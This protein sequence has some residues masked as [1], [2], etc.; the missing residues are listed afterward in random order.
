MASLVIVSRSQL[1]PSHQQQIEKWNEKVTGRSVRFYQADVSDPDAIHNLIR[2]VSKEYQITAVYH[3]A[4]VV[5]DCSL[6]SMTTDQLTRAMNGKVWGA[7]HLHNALQ[8][9]WPLA[10]LVL[11]SSISV[12]L[13]TPGQGN[14]V[15]A[16]ACLEGLAN[17]RRK[18]HLPVQLLNWGHWA[19][20]GMASHLDQRQWAYMN[21]Q[22]ITPVTSAQAFVA[23]SELQ[24][25]W[26]HNTDNAPQ[27]VTV[28][29]LNKEAIT[30]NPQNLLSTMLSGSVDE[31]Q[32]TSK[33]ESQIPGKNALP[34]TSAMEDFQ[35]WPLSRIQKHVATR[36]VN[37]L[38]RILP[39]GGRSL[40]NSQPLERQGLDSLLGVEF[41]S[42]VNNEFR[43]T[44][45]GSLLFNYPTVDAL[46]EHLSKEIHAHVRSSVKTTP[47]AQSK[48]S[49]SIAI[50][51]MGCRFPGGVT[52]PEEFWQLLVNNTDAITSCPADR[53]EIDDWYAPEPG[54]PAKM[55]SR[56]GGF[57]SDIY[58]FDTQFF[59]VNPHEAVFLDPRQRLLMEVAWEALQ[60]AGQ[61]CKRLNNSRTSVY[62]GFC[63]SEYQGLV[64]T[65]ASEITPYSLL[66]TSFSAMASRLSY[67]LGLNGPNIALD[68]ACSSS[69]VAIDM[70]CKSLRD[71]DSDLAIAGGSNLLLTPESSVYFSQ[72]KALSPSDRYHSFGA[73][74]DGYV[75]AEG[76]GVVILKRLDRA[77][78]D[79]DPIDAIIRSVAVNQDGRS[80]GPTAPNGL[81]QRNLLQ[82]VLE[83]AHVK[84][85]QV[86]YV[87]AH[88]TG[89]PLGDPV[90]TQALAEVYETVDGAQLS[91]RE[92]PLLIGSVKSNIG[93]TEAAAG[94]A[95]VIKTVLALQ[96]RMIPASL[97]A[98][99]ANPRCSEF[100]STL[101]VASEN[102][103]IPETVSPLIAGVSSFG[104]SGTNGHLLV[105]SPPV[106]QS[107]NHRNDQSPQLICLSAKSQDVL[108]LQVKCLLRF[109]SDQ[110][111]CSLIRLAQS[112]VLTRDSFN[113]RLA[114]VVESVE[115]LIHDL[116]RLDNA[117]IAKEARLPVSDRELFCSW[118]AEKVEAAGGLTFLFGD[119]SPAKEEFFEDLRGRESA[120][121]SV[122]DEL[123]NLGDWQ[124][125]TFRDFACNYALGQLWL[126]RGVE[127]DQVMGEGA[128]CA[129]SLLSGWQPHSRTGYCHDEPRA[130]Q[131]S[132][133]CADTFADDHT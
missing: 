40:N 61:T 114:F 104:F 94:V 9:R 43:L 60:R 84:P 113:C 90:E 33:A 31:Q 4:G 51:G 26:P 74:A 69:L 100:G 121:A 79:G 112:L 27:T 17:L 21:R 19:G 10:N 96:H 59:E 108:A 32:N 22:G 93:H 91:C 95:G 115:E 1:T 16:N 20:S 53:W 47:T 39:D 125:K 120:Y 66:G 119:S 80:Q 54:T 129:G 133:Q 23:L 62:A 8:S 82:S 78:A 107:V 56:G 102:T 118:S 89:T 67:W 124:D 46:V 86:T 83:Q 42:Y 6:G 98:L 87:E 24:K 68:T 48:S 71:G 70:A 75:R 37:G 72:L 57:L 123:K 128:G 105:E 103:P 28:F 111:D 77:L 34:Q 109:V 76:C 73:R 14:Y 52:T 2:D 101:K 131:C 49:S 30:G 81:A 126:T 36:V 122:I 64:M 130:R 85:E 117:D 99:P 65:D 35:D 5:E 97:H 15:A 116:T 58:D 55:V 110:P 7:W 13:G 12:L 63:G 88:G 11:F 44:M 45:P 29:S 3:L 92:E 106:Q 50:I 18:Q 127:P 25:A 38:R 132:R 41:R